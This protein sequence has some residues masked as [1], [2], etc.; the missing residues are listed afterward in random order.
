MHKDA[1]VVLG[2]RAANG[3]QGGVLGRAEARRTASGYVF[4]LMLKQDR[5][6]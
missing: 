3:G 5:D 6:L 4:G 1:S 2:F